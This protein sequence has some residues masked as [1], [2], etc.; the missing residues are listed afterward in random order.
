MSGL[1]T[2]AQSSNF[3]I[4]NKTDCDVDV[5]FHCSGFSSGSTSIAAQSVFSSTCPTSTWLC[6]VE[7]EFPSS[8]VVLTGNPYSY[9]GVYC[10]VPVETTPIDICYTQNT[11]WQNYITFIGCNIY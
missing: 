2:K 9:G 5:T 1:D 8:N 10:A 3:K 11:D 7:M 6:Y 4:A